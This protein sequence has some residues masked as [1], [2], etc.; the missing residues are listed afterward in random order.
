MSIRKL[1]DM[2]LEEKAINKNAFF[3]REGK[4]NDRRCLH[5][6]DHIS[7]VGNLRDLCQ[8][9]KILSLRV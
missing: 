1:E 4:S 8:E 7:L 5:T 6:L 3:L 2:K 9:R